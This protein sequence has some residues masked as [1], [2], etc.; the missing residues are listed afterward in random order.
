VK[1]STEQRPILATSLAAELALA[2]D[3][4]ARLA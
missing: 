2:R 3:T 4:L 1:R